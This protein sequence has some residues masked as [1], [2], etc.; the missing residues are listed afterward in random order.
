MASLLPGENGTH[1][2][3]PTKNGDLQGTFQ[4]ASAVPATTASRPKTEQG[5]TGPAVLVT[6]RS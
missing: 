6:T 4:G 2:N 3:L 1:R 5:A